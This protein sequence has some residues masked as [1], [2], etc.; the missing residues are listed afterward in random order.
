[1]RTNTPQIPSICCSAVCGNTIAPRQRHPHLE[2]GAGQRPLVAVEPQEIAEPPGV[3]RQAR[4]QSFHPRGPPPAVAAAHLGGGADRPQLGSRQRQL[5]PHHGG[6]G[7]HQ[8]A[9]P[10]ARRHVFA[11]RHRVAGQGAGPRRPHHDGGPALAGLAAARHDR[12][13]GG[14]LLG[15]GHRRLRKPPPRARAPKWRHARAAALHVRRRAA[16]FRREPAPPA[17]APRRRPARATGSRARQP[18]EPPRPP[19]PR[20]RPPPGRRPQPKAGSPRSGPTPP[21]RQTRRSPGAPRRLPRSSPHAGP[22]DA[23][24]HRPPLRARA[25]RHFGARAQAAASEAAVARAE[26]E[27]PPARRSWRAAARPARAGP[28]VVRAPRAGTLAG[29]SG[30]ARRK[31]GGGRPAGLAGDARRRHGAGRAAA[32]GSR[33]VD[34]R[35]HRRGAPQRRPAVDRAGGRTAAAPGDRPPAAQLFPAARRRR[36]AAGRHPA[37]GAGAAGERDRVAAD[38]PAAD[39][40]DLGVFVRTGSEAEFR[41]VRKAPSWA[42]P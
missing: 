30:G 10:G 22:R 9:Q 16:P 42:A 18:L 32:A 29:Y 4:R 8:R 6:A 21:R 33:A 35:R 37:R 26:E 39:R 41:P 40:R 25:W 3:G 28:S 12:R 34:G 27:R 23:G 36:A 11:E 2:R 7:C 20:A 19:G 15:A 14:V 38:R 31:H 13:A 1:M 24:R 5:D 17:S